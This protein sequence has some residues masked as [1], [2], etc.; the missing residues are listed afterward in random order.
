MRVRTHVIFPRVDRGAALPVSCSVKK[1][2]LT[3]KGL[4]PPLSPHCHAIRY[5]HDVDQEVVMDDE[6]QGIA[7]HL[8]S[9]QAKGRYSKKCNSIGIVVG[10]V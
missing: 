7:I 5:R 4:P 2:S 6:L 10:F 3:H 9:I 8:V 1:R